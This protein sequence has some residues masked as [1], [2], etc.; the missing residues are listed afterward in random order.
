MADFLMSDAKRMK[1]SAIYTFR[2]NDVILIAVLLLPCIINDL[3]LSVSAASLLLLLLI[4]RRLR[5][6]KKMVIFVLPI[7]G[8]MAFG[9]VNSYEH[10]IYAIFKDVWYFLNPLIAIALG[11]FL[12]S[13]RTSQ[14]TIMQAV[15]ISGSIAACVHLVDFFANIGYVDSLFNVRFEY[16]IKGYYITA[17]ALPC[18]TYFLSNK[19]VFRSHSL[20][21]VPA[22]LLCLASVLLSFSRTFIV[23]SAVI[24]F[25]NTERFRLSGINFFK[26]ALFMIPA[27]I[28]LNFHDGVGADSKF[29]EKVVRSLSEVAISDYQT[30]KDINLN[31][32]GYES[33]RAVVDYQSGSWQERIVGQGLGATI[34]LGIEISLGDREFRY[35]P[36]IHNGYLQLLVKTGLI[37]FILY[38]YFLGSI[39]FFRSSH[40]SG[41]QSLREHQSVVRLIRGL[42]FFLVL[43]SLVVT[44]IFNQGIFSVLIL[45]GLMV[46]MTSGTRSERRAVALN[47]SR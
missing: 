6:Q 10:S 21:L 1:T 35:V 13:S 7:L 20:V 41:F 47:M 14:A 15:C 31:W 22:L 11:Y 3:I 25:I 27:S 4:Q 28:L 45:L 43:A 32:R 40:A 46:A 44:G 18:F 17:I 29:L 26:L 36:I 16:G 24:F 42:G 38:I 34:D 19:A 23:L 39:V 12:F 33:Y 37:G 9:T 2:A 5:L 8:S 30:N